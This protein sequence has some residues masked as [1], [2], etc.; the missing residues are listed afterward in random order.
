[1][2][3]A[4]LFLL[5]FLSFYS[6]AQIKGSI[7]DEKGKPLPFVSVF[8]ENTYNGTTS[9][10]QGNYQLNIKSGGKNK[11]VFQ[12]LGFKTKKIAIPTEKSPFTLDV[13]MLEESYSLNEVVINPKN[14][15][16]NAVI[17]KDKYTN[18][19]KN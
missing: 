19:N 8:E 15:P 2:K 18:E 9:N 3:K 5:L 7:T 16:A 11:I 6:N 12:L 17:K 13:N 4:Y 10:E 1:M 14:N